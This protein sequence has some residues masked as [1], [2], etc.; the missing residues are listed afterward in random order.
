M[1]ILLATDGSKHSN[2]AAA[3]LARLPYRDKV[4]VTV[5]SVIPAMAVWSHSEAPDWQQ[6]YSEAQTKQANQ[7]CLEIARV[8]DGANTTVDTVISTGHPGS[9]IVSEAQQRT[10][11]LVVIGAMGH[12]A[13][14]RM[15]VGSVSDYVANHASCSVLVVRP[16]GLGLKEH[17]QLN[18][19]VGFDN[20]DQS[21]YALKELE[22]FQWGAQTHF[23]IVNGFGT[24]FN[25]LDVPVEIDMKEIQEM[26]Q[27]NL[28]AV[29]TEAREASPNLH[30]HLIQM[31][32]IGEGL[33]EFTREQKSDLIVVGDSGYGLLGRAILG[34]VSRYVLRH[35]PCSVWI[36]RKPRY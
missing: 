13:L 28:N 29:S 10:S 21:K 1:K 11:D 16:T 36:A 26:L 8:F 15:M 4:D 12:S 32:H 31:L 24:P 19:C 30:P 3:F 5:M 18:V 17:R 34:S 25:H 27:R 9:Q 2:E 22:S 23:D 6:R 33:A 20:S 35:A 14:E 7:A